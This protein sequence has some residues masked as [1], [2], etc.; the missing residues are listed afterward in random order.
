METGQS[1]GTSNSNYPCA[2]VPF[3][4][5]NVDHSSLYSSAPSSCRLPFKQPIN[6]TRV[7]LVYPLRLHSGCTRCTGCTLVDTPPITIPL[8]ASW[9]DSALLPRFQHIPVAWHLAA[10]LLLSLSL[11]THFVIPSPSLCRHLDHLSAPLD[12]LD[13]GATT[14]AAIL[15]TSVRISAT[16]ACDETVFCPALYRIVGL[17]RRAH[18]PEIFSQRHNVRRIRILPT[19]YPS[20]S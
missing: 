8:H 13:H 4:R 2:A 14:L 16:R 3:S 11:S 6:V 17:D 12:T 18:S 7:K 19:S 20:R 9:F 1:C 10:R 15:Y 5:D